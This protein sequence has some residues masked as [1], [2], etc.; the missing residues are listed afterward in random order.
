MTKT[1]KDSEKRKGCRDG[2][3]FPVVPFNGYS[4][5]PFDSCCPCPWARSGAYTS[6]VIVMEIDFL[7]PLNGTWWFVR[8]IIDDSIHSTLDCVG[9]SSAD[10][11]KD[12]MRYF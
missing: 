4:D 3:E 12:I 8:N 9:N 5:E 6:L 2:S 11:L 1:H 7:L 10:F